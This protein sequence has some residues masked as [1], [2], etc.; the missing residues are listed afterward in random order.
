MPLPRQLPQR[1]RG[2]EA[3]V[4][5]VAEGVVPERPLVPDDLRVLEQRHHD[6]LGDDEP[7]RD[8]HGLHAGLS[9]L[10]HLRVGLPL[11]PGV[12]FEQQDGPLPGEEHVG[13][14]RVGLVDVGRLLALLGLAC[15]Q[16]E[17]PL[18]LRLLLA[19]LPVEASLLLPV[20]AFGL[21]AG[22]RFEHRLGL[23]PRSLGRPAVHEA[24]RWASG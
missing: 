3:H 9:V 1:G 15:R 23:G 21:G 2:A 10:K 20:L 17:V 16:R 18:P 7:V 11:H 24:Q 12:G 19:C 8:A 4:A 13:A 6:G 22:L 14:G 5:G